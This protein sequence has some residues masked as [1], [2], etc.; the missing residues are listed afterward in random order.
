LS[1]QGYEP[2]KLKISKETATMLD[3]KIPQK[4]KSETLRLKNL[5]RTLI[6]LYPISHLPKQ[7]PE[8]VSAPERA[9]GLGITCVSYSKDICIREIENFAESFA[10]LIGISSFDS[11]FTR[12]NLIDATKIDFLDELLL[13]EGKLSSIYPTS[14]RDDVKKTIPFMADKETRDCLKD[15]KSRRSLILS[16]I[17]PDLQKKMLLLHEKQLVD[18][19]YAVFCG[20]CKKHIFTAEKTDDIDETLSDRECSCGAE[21]NINKI[22]EESY[23]VTKSVEDSIE[24]GVWLVSK[25]EDDLLGFGVSE[26]FIRIGIEIDGNETDLVFAYLGQ[27]VVVE[28]KTGRFDLGHAFKFSAK[29]LRLKPA[30]AIVIAMDGVDEFAKKHLETLTK[31]LEI[32]FVYLEGET[33]QIEKGLEQ[34]LLDLQLLRTKELAEANLY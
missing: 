34:F 28:C 30:Y 13:K 19:K 3:L 16:K 21:L 14:K 31:E 9:E 26:D 29:I 18:K 2:L 24:Q 10:K 5:E 15:L 4:L 32:E 1:D 17:N 25:V 23:S 6:F 11:I 20:K 12:G 7:T 8:K 33:S 27:L 22:I